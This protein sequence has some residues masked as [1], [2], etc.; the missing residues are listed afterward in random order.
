M[1][2]GRTGGNNNF[3]NPHDSEIATWRENGKG[4]CAEAGGIKK[5]S[6]HFMFERWLV[7]NKN[8]L[9]GWEMR[10]RTV[11]LSKVLIIELFSS[12][13]TNLLNYTKHTSFTFHLFESM[14]INYFF[15]LKFFFYYGSWLILSYVCFRYTYMTEISQN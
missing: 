8:I 13:V 3:K 9:Q 11:F 10:L 15:I 12:H 4:M 14:R 1:L 2:L 5:D 7:E 6:Q